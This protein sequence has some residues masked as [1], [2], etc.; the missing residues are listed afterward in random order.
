MKIYYIIR[1]KLYHFYTREFSQDIY[2]MNKGKKEK[3]NNNNPIIEKNTKIGFADANADQEFLFNCYIEKPEFKDIE[4][5]SNRYYIIKGRT[6]SGKTAILQNIQY[7]HDNVNYIDLTRLSTD[8]IANSNIMKFLNSIDADL[9]I[10]FQILWKHVLCLEYIKI[11]YKIDSET[12]INNFISS[13]NKISFNLF[14][15]EQKQIAYDYVKEWG[16][17]FWIDREENVKEIFEKFSGEVEANLDANLVNKINAG[18]NISSQLSREKKIEIRDRIK[19]I[20]KGN[21]LRDLQKVIDVISVDRTNKKIIFFIL[22]DELDTHWAEEKI[23]FRM[24]RS[25]ID[26]LSKFQQ[27]EDLKICIAIRDDVLERT[28]Y[29]TKN[30]SFQREKID[31][32]ILQLKWNKVELKSL[33][34]KRIQHLY[35]K[36]Y[37]KE[38]VKFSDIFCNKVSNIDTFEYLIERTFMRPRDIIVFINECLDKAS[39]KTSIEANDIKNAEKEYSRKR[40]DSVLQE[41]S[42]MYSE[43]REIVYFISYKKQKSLILKSLLED[44]KLLEELVTNLNVTE[45]GNSSK[46]NQSALTYYNSA[47]SD[48]DSLKFCMDICA[49]T[50]ETGI[51]GIKLSA[52]TPVQYS[53]LNG[54]IINPNQ[55]NEDAKIY[56]HPMFYSALAINEKK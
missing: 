13:V 8:Y 43:L 54:N 12:K 34:E 56:I 5:N 21:Q 17:N 31:D 46:I 40:L 53:Y 52:Q 50:Y 10:L 28:L 7:K 35:Q 32:Y 37:S 33:V 49:Y 25:L 47:M 11:K 4:K 6:G 48:F 9:S 51:I 20:I 27:I 3:K 18:T 22:I 38:N 24:I 55:I 29:E 36:Q 39:H 41:W 30:I 23:R 19:S 16:R 15:Y 1:T 14:K 2:E 44:K 45:K 26:T 42:S